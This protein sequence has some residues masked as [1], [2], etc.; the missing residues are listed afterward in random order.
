[1]PGAPA[2]PEPACPCPRTLREADGGGRAGGE[3]QEH[4]RE[5]EAFDSRR[6]PSSALYPAVLPSLLLCSPSSSPSL[7]KA[8]SGTHSPPCNFLTWAAHPSVSP[9]WGPDSP[10]SVRLRARPSKQSPKVTS[11]PTAPS[12]LTD[13]SQ[14]PGSKLWFSSSDFPSSILN[15]LPPLTHRRKSQSG[16]LTRTL[17]TIIG[18]RIPSFGRG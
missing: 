13:H 16:G 17:F 3:T 12:C 5:H 2:Q 10:T 9:G 1:M 7:P 4:P 15:P 18:H 6:E 8:T 11:L 14:T